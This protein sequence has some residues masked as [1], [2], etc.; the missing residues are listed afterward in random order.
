MIAVSLYPLPALPENRF[1][2]TDKLGHL[3]AFVLLSVTYLRAF[4]LSDPDNF[5]LNRAI[6]YS[7]MICAAIGGMIELLQHYLPIRRFGDWFD[8]Y[9]DIAGISLG[10]IFYTMINKKRLLGLFSLLILN[11]FCFGQSIESARIFQE[12]LNLEFGD[13]LE[14]PLD[15]IDLVHFKSLEF[16]PIDEKYIVE[17][18]LVKQNSPEFFTMETTTSRRPEYRVWAYAYF[19]L[20]GKEQKL[21]IYQSKKLMNT[22]DYGDY[23]FLP[24]SDLTNGESTYYGGRYV[25]LRIPEGDSI[26][27]DFNKSYN[28]YCAYSNRY[29]CPKV[30]SENALDLPINA[31]VKK[32]H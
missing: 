20:E 29:S 12:E 28:P 19:T 17:A 3:L 2:P 22:L 14:S 25:D 30:P 11:Q 6:V 7:F 32:F 5:R 26:I 9:F 23:L 18:S 1:I 8:F 4:R 10:I 27:I 21:T 15:S 16:F 24:F 31:G 13:S